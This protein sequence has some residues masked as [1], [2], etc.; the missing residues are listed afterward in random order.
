MAQAEEKTAT[1]DSQVLFQPQAPEVLKPQVLVK[2][3]DM[4]KQES[5]LN[6]KKLRKMFNK[7]KL[8]TKITEEVKCI[9]DVKVNL[10]AKILAY[11]NNLIKY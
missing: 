8:N 3:A 4:E 2:E 7:V 9:N 10:D 5:Q 6:K 1:I 11:R